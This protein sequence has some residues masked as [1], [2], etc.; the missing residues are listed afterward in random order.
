M[1]KKRVS[2]RWGSSGAGLALISAVLF[3][4]TTP[5]SKILLNEVSPWLIAGLLYLGSGLGLLVIWLA[6]TYGLRKPSSEATLE[7]GSWFWLAGAVF[8]GGILAPV[9]LMWG[10]TRTMAST[11]SLM[12]NLEGVMTAL[13][14]WF[15]FKEN[16]DRRIAMGMLFIVAGGVILSW[17]NDLQAGVPWGIL[18]IAGACF[19]WALDN[20]LTRQVSGGDPQQIAMIK[21]LVAGSVNTAIALGAGASL[22]ALGTLFATGIVGLLGY[23]LSL[24][25]FIL[26]L[27]HI[28]TARAGAYFSTAPFIGA[29]LS[30]VILREAPSAPLIIAGVLM[31][32]GVWLHLTER[33]EHI[34][35][36]ESIT[37]TH[38]HWHDDHHQHEHPLG[39]SLKEPHSHEHVH[40]QMTHSHPHFPDLHHRHKHKKE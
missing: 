15:V 4:A 27:R 24:Y 37:H 17:S 9:L 8:V 2:Q 30:A 29:V 38:L 19:C 40:S 10:L 11:A 14:A 28:G 3:G 18:A 31:L 22:P 34:H 16:F 26:A 32:I 5:F 21:G 36:H 1:R 39:T 13:L 6:R 20:N 7:R 35:T 12:L 25:L 33:H 23:G